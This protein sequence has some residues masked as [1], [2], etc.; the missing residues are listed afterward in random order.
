M[1]IGKDNVCLSIFSACA[2]DAV[3][4]V[5]S[6]C[7]RFGHQFDEKGACLEVK[8]REVFEKNG[9]QAVELKRRIDGHDLQID[10]LFVWENILF[11]VECKNYALPSETV[12]SKH[13]FW[14]N[15]KEAAAQLVRQV[16]ILEQNPQLVREE[17]H[18][19]VQWERVVPV[20]LNG[21]PFSLPGLHWGVYFYDL[22][23]LWKFF[24][25]GQIRCVNEARPSVADVP[26]KGE[27]TRLWAGESP[28]EKDFFASV[29][30]NKFYELTAGEFVPSPLP[31]RVSER[32]MV[33]TSI[34][35]RSEMVLD[36]MV[37]S[38]LGDDR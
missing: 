16:A 15:Q 11:I 4:L 36:E 22:V 18:R 20:V 35:G 1:K 31:F 8:V 32:L 2:H 5:L 3:R 19:D 24:A 37:R 7:G 12:Q 9:I 21:M 10:C 38:M 33:L 34:V 23:S 29:E 6:Q 14:I 17:L 30:N 28:S 27:D 25:S 26:H 13:T